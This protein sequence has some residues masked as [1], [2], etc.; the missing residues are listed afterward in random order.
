MHQDTSFGCASVTH[1]GKG[2]LEDWLRLPYR[3]ALAYD[4]A[5]PVAVG[6]AAGATVALEMHV[7]FAAL[8]K[9]FLELMP[10][11]RPLEVDS[12]PS[13]LLQYLNR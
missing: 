4:P 10:L 7:Y 6:V 9:D 1:P 8:W 12:P 11:V 5:A 3:G 2:P 13:R